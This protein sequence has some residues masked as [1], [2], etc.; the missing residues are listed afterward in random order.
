M[1]DAFEFP[2]WVVAALNR[3]STTA[4]A[5]GRPASIVSHR[6]QSVW[7]LLLDAAVVGP[8]LPRDLG[9]GADDDQTRRADERAVLDFAETT[10]T[11]AGVKWLL[12]H[13]ARIELLN[14][15]GPGEDLNRALERT[16]RRFS[17]PFSIALRQYLQPQPR[18][19]VSPDLSALEATRTALAAIDGVTAFTLPRLDQLDREVE[20]A[21]LLAQFSRMVGEKPGQPG[22][23]RFFGRT[24]E[25][26]TL[27]DYCEGIEAESIGTQVARIAYRAGRAFRGGIVPHIVWGVGGVGKTTL[28]A[29]FMLEHVRASR[30]RWPFAYLDFDRSTVNAGH[31]T[32]LL[33]EMCTQVAAQFAELSEPLN[34]LRLRLQTLAAKTETLSSSETLPQ[35][36]PC[37]Q[38]FRSQIDRIVEGGDSLIT[39]SRPFLLVFDTFEIVQYEADLVRHLEEF[40]ALFNN[41]VNR[42]WGRLRLIIAGR[43]EVP[44]F[45]GSVQSVPLGPLDAAGSASM[46][47][48][49]AS[50]AMVMLPI[51]EASSIVG[52]IARQVSGKANDGVHPLQLRLLGTVIDQMKK[53]REAEGKTFSTQMLMSELSQQNSTRLAGRIFINS[54]LVRRILNHVVDRRV[55][56][57]ADPGLVVRRITKDVIVNV[58]APSTNPPRPGGA[59]DESDDEVKTPWQITDD[60]AKDIYKA[61]SKEVTLIE[62]D[63]GALRHRPDVRQEMLPLIRARRPKRY[64]DMHRRAFEHFAGELRTDPSDDRAAY[65]AIY[66]GLWKGEKLEQLHAWWRVDP[67]FTPKID[68]EE[69][70]AGSPENIFLRA[71]ALADLN[72]DEVWQMPRAVALGWLSGRSE[73]LLQVDRVNLATMAIIRSA[74]GQDLEGV[75]D[76]PG[77][78]ATVARLLFRGGEWHD[79]VRLLSRLLDKP[80]TREVLS[81]PPTPDGRQSDYWSLLRTFVTILAKSGR[82][83]DRIERY[84][85]LMSK[86][87]DPLARVEFVIYRALSAARQDGAA[88]TRVQWRGEI[89]DALRQVPVEQWRRGMRILRTAVLILGEREEEWLISYAHLCDTLPRDRQMGATVATVLEPVLAGSADLIERLR[90]PKAAA[91]NDPATFVAIDNVWR[92]FSQEQFE[93]FGLREKASFVALVAEDQLEWVR[94]IGNAL[95]RELVSRTGPEVQTWLKKSDFGHGPAVGADQDGLSYAQTAYEAGRFRELIEGLQSL[96]EQREGSFRGGNYPRD[97]FELADVFNAYRRTVLGIVHSDAPMK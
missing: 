42:P 33:T 3:K 63:G 86:A 17:D 38:E 89:L 87:P 55:R 10:Q 46:L 1:S 28:V 25:L 13:E 23:D 84:A 78:A 88:K 37:A 50:D 92:R 68:A 80:E 71:K 73:L 29:K 19:T 44:S 62:P 41:P 27:R 31:L 91:L 18:P 54:V 11:P 74:I 76:R 40:V 93:Q 48:S 39:G 2:D 51:Q 66:H 61:F 12:R 49:L 58:M 8:F 22:S 26:K 21:R 43:R 9:D 67:R 90:E 6:G 16:R 35:L 52:I 36:R 96:G 15:S 14:A 72:A 57:L 77:L 20:L 34:D 30:S 97:V 69:F 81:S 7:Q 65:E 70:L 47:Q 75:D 82:E 94:P 64:A 45:L 24:V 32:A 79:A 60:E 53:E 59:V 85:G 83:R 95:T 5:P 4:A 56:A